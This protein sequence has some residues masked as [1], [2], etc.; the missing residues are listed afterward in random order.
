M[1]DYGYMIYQAERA[2][3]RTEQREADADLGR[4][5]AALAGL[6]QSLAQPARALLRRLAQGPPPA[7]VHSDC[8]DR[9]VS[10]QPRPVRAKLS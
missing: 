10:C 5:A 4:Q 6:C 1:P 9:E 2:M 8:R 7:R 3:T